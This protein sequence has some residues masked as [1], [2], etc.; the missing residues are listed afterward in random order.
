MAFEGRFCTFKL[1][2]E[3]F[4]VEAGFVLEVLRTPGLSPIPLAP[5][6][7]AGLM[8][9]RGQVLTVLNLRRRLGLPEQGPGKGAMTVILKS[10]GEW[11][12]LEVDGIGDVLD[13]ESR[14][15]EE[16]PPTLTGRARDLIRGAFKLREGLLQ[17]LDLEK[18]VD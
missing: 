5:E 17:V 11:I 7:V 15:F 8:N 2:G 1:G 13:A 9:L 16:P 14:F 4:G 18:A 12:G 10:K 6:P 3:W